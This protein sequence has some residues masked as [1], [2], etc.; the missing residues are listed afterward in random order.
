MSSPASPGRAEKAKLRSWPRPPSVS[1]SRPPWGPL[2]A[3]PGQLK[4]APNS[5]ATAQCG[6]AGGAT[7]W[8]GGLGDWDSQRD[9]SC[10]SQRTAGI[11]RGGRGARALLKE[12]GPWHYGQDSVLALNQVGIC[13]RASAGPQLTP[14][15]CP[16]LL[17]QEAHPAPDTADA[18]GLP[19]FLAAGPLSPTPAP[20]G[21]ALK[22]ELSSAGRRIRPRDPQPANPHARRAPRPPQVTATAPGP[23]CCPEAQPDPVLA[24][25]RNAR[26]GSASAPQ[27]RPGTATL[28]T[29][30]AGGNQRTSGNKSNW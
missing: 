23:P 5:H 22:P 13:P 11:S 27:H 2:G 29:R 21:Y 15:L 16:G 24:R 3:S 8:W 6:A 17:P 26:P 30:V 25:G 14:G 20:H 7:G 28:V 1:C 4:R 10:R 12:W 19:G 18:L 9:R